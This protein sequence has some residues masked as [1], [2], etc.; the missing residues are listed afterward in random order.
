MG[1]YPS[2]GVCGEPRSMCCP[3]LFRSVPSR[4]LV[5]GAM[6]KKR[7][8]GRRHESVTADSLRRPAQHG[9]PPAAKV[10][11]WGNV[12]V[13][14]ALRTPRSRHHSQLSA[15]TQGGQVARDPPLRS[16]FSSF[17][18]FFYSNLK[19]RLRREGALPPKPS[20]IAL[21]VH[22]RRFVFW[23][24]QY[25]APYPLPAG[26]SGTLCADHCCGVTAPIGPRSC[27]VFR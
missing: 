21:H 13:H 5:V 6:S 4:I 1:G 15:Q 16:E 24:P 2:D 27:T 10:A 25:Q 3:R 26:S 22:R 7:S 23:L 8:K 20:A 17:L 14:I 9:L 19:K 18:L 11:N 12:Q